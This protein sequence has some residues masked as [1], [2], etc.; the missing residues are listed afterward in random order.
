MAQA[1]FSE[2][3]REAVCNLYEFDDDETRQKFKKFH[4]NCCVTLRIMNSTETIDV[5]ALEAHNIETY[6]LA[7][8]IFPF[9]DW[10][11]LY[12]TFL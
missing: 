4:Q 6:L 11:D 12:I 2:K 9:M 8:E 7:K 10:L 5:E 3:N 1:F